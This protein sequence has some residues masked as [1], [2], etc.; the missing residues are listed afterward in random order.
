[1]LC[2]RPPTRSVGAESE[3][4]VRE[5][6]L[7]YHMSMTSVRDVLARWFG[8]AGVGI[9][10]IGTLI[11]ASGEFPPLRFIPDLLSSHDLAKAAWESIL[12]PV[13]HDGGFSGAPQFRLESGDLGFDALASILVRRV[14]LLTQS[15]ISAVLVEPFMG[16]DELVFYTVSVK[17]EGVDDGFTVA[18][19]ASITS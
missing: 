12:P 7:Q 19:S 3:E 14:P 11:A 2:F 16:R 13:F 8:I 15:P 6:E 4:F 18:E 10:L 1:M 17:I 5:V 9:A